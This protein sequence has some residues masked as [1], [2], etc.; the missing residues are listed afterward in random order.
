MT[1]LATGN[2]ISIRNGLGQTKF[3]SND[4]LVFRK[5]VHTGSGNLGYGSW[6]LIA[7]LPGVIMTDKDFPIVQIV[8]TGGNGNK[9]QSLIGQQILMNFSLPVHFAHDA[10]SPSI[11]HYTYMSA[12][13]VDLG[14]GNWGF[15]ATMVDTARKC[16]RG[17]PAGYGNI[18]ISLNWKVSIISYL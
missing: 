1:L 4:K 11:T 18:G 9:V 10:T 16:W 17:L 15:A 2:T 13:L 6:A 5:S 7:G 14:I 3:T 8:I 12:S